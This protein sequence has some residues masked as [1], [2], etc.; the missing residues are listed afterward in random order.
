MESKIRWTQGRKKILCDAS[1]QCL[2]DLFLAVCSKEARFS[3][4]FA[5]AAFCS[6]CRLSICTDEGPALEAAGSCPHGVEAGEAKGEGT[7]KAMG[8]SF[9]PSPSLA[10]VP[11]VCCSCQTRQVEISP[12][13][14]SG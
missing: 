8:K 6:D 13:G 3:W 10:A 4:C 7:I 5:G 2:K 9:R 14:C 12:P 11:A 1:V